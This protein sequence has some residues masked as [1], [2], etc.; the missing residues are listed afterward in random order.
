MTW[1]LLIFT[2]V[3][4]YAIS[5]V[6][7]RLLLKNDKTEPISFSVFFQVG[8][9]VVIGIFALILNQN[10]SIPNLTQVGGNLLLMTVLYSLANI[11]IFKSLKITQ[12]S[13][14]TV[15]FSSRTL[16]AVLGVS[17]VFQEGLTIVQW[18][19]AAL[20]ILGVVIVTFKKIG[21]KINKGDIFALLA[22]LIFG[23]ANTNDRLLVKFFDPYSYV[24][25]GFLLPGL[26]IGLVYPQK[27]QNLKKYFQKTFIHKMLLLC[28]LYGLSALAF[29]GALQIGPNS[30]QVFAINAFGAIIT[31]LLAIAF[32]RERDG[33][34]KKII[35]VVISVIGLLLVNK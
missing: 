18:L 16:F 20:I 19:G 12:A 8:V 14:F 6:L 26:L 5:T 28:F 23:L 22:A 13:K 15:I 31:V 10:F 7:Q 32:L 11:L 27:L 24:V 30:S 25:I 29:F 9:A 21:T 35:G 1:Q 2:S 33:I 4:L 17:L 3:I 34:Y